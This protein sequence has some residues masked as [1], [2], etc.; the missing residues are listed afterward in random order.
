MS[1]EPLTEAERQSSRY[2][3]S[4]LQRARNQPAIDLLHKWLADQTGY[5]EQAWPATKRAI[6]ENALAS[7]KRFD[8]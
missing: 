2:L 7:R 6:T 8:V 1:K 3:S 5:D 4:A